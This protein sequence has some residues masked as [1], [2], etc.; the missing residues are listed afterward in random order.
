M[1]V[2]QH[3]RNSTPDNLY[4]NNCP[5]S[6]S[7]ILIFRVEILNFEKIKK[8]IAKFLPFLKTFKIC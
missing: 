1:A 5:E 4:A 2:W 6:G 8:L 7:G 3:I